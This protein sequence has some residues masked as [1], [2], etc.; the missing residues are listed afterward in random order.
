M[1]RNARLAKKS[2]KIAAILYFVFGAIGFLFTMTVPIQVTLNDYTTRGRLWELTSEPG[3]F[4]FLLIV[5]LVPFIFG[6][7]GLYLSRN[8]AVNP[9]LGKAIFFIIAGFISVF[10]F[11]GFVYIF[12]GI[13][14]LM[15]KKKLDV[16]S[17]K[18][19][20]LE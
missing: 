13:Q 16:M 7:I 18:E 10:F 9:T 14:T 8:L 3:P 12:A 5:L 6:L 19:K 20:L 17:S 4:T 15:A 2:S 11:V 1:G